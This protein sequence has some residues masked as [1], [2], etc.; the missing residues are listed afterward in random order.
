MRVGLIVHVVDSR[1]SLKGI[2]MKAQYESKSFI[3]A[4]KMH[5][6]AKQANKAQ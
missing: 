3:G 2:H 5:M 4:Y 6:L 1:V